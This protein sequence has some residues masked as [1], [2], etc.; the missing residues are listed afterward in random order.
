MPGIEALL[1]EE[2]KQNLEEARRLLGLRSRAELFRFFADNA[3]EIAK[4]C[5]DIK[6][7]R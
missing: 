5:S 7:K 6:S 3:I 2:Q 4:K 1:T